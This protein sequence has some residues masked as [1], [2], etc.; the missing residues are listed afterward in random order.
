MTYPL[1]AHTES[2]IWKTLHEDQTPARV[3]LRIYPAKTK[4]M[5]MKTQELQEDRHT[6][7]K[8]VQHYKHLSRHI[9]ADRDI[10]KRHLH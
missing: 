9:S 1:L 7:Q 2:E 6:E 8:K 3:R 4:V 10:K 5:K